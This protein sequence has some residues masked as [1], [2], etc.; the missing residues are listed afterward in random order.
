MSGNLEVNKNVAE[1]VKYL[2]ERLPKYPDFPKKGILFRSV[3]I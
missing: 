2:E 3:K 1:V